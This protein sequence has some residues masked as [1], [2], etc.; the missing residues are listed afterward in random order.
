MT[1][2]QVDIVIVTYRSERFLPRLLE[3]LESMSQLEHAIHLFDNTGNP[4]TLSRAWNDLAAAGQAPFI[5]FLNPDCVLSPGWDSALKDVL[6]RRANLGIVRPPGFHGHMPSREEMVAVAKGAPEGE[7]ER[8]WDCGLDRGWFCSMM[9]RSQFEALRGFDERLRFFGQDWDIVRRMQSRLG[10][11][12]AHA[13]RCQIW[14]Q[15]G[16]SRAEGAARGEFSDDLEY[17]YFQWIWERLHNGDLK[18]WDLLTN[19]ERNLV[20]QDPLFSKM[21]SA[22]Q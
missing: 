11:L 5:V 21:M 20:R 8:H 15:I 22:W 13:N 2:P 17:G 9:R 14:H 4:T 18:D 3:D 1:S 12:F 6:D 19:D 10:L 7:F 16:G